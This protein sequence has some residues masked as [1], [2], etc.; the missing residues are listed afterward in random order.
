MEQ[1]QLGRTDL[2]VSPVGLGCWQFSGGRGLGG[3][4]WPALPQEDVDAIV[5]RS[6]A[7][8]VNWFDT[9]EAYGGGF[10]EQSLA[11]A[12]D[13]IGAGSGPLLIAT[14]WW[15]FL[16]RA[17]NMRTTIR[18]RIEALGGRRVDLYQI[19]QRL[20]FSSIRSQM[21][22]LADLVQAGLARSVG[23]S[24]F[25]AKAMHEAARWLDRRGVPLASNQV[26]FHLLDRRIETNGVMEAARELGV[27]IIAYS[28]LAQGI[29]SG[30][31]H[32]DPDR[33]A[34][35]RDVRK[36]M[37]AF[38][39]SAL[40][41]AAPVID[42]LGRIASA[43]ECSRAQV[44]L[45]WLMRAHGDRVVVIP[46]ARTVSQ[47]EENAASMSVWLSEEESE[48]LSEATGAV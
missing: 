11:T 42:E 18:R 8:G 47:A 12:L 33:L 3:R 48:R 5:E 46:G 9:A 10:S 35:V 15:P 41:A 44:A 14:K 22:V 27:T 26:R 16:R 37:P 17:G 6:V 1:R 21:E 20:S 31:F 25:G 4:F 40:A 45:A 24:N 38:R 2:R 34:D 30:K 32:D 13:R 19:H 7:R 29:L 23:V 39:R 43:H 28:P 36:R